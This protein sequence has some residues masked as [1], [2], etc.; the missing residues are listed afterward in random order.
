[1]IP[2]VYYVTFA[3]LIDSLLFFII[4]VSGKPHK[5][6]DDTGAA[7]LVLLVVSFGGLRSLIVVMSL[8]F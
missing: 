8:L 5:P 3:A 1:V 4:V 6:L 7:R 2:E